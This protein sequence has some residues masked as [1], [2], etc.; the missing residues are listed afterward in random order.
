MKLL[1]IMRPHEGVDVRAEI[2]SRADAELRALWDLYGSDFVREM[3]T[4]GGPGAVLV[5]EA[6]SPDQARRSLEELPLLGNRV[7]DLEL[8]ELH[9]FTALRMLFK[10]PAV[11]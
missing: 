2:A 7:M 8:I 5:L 11:L 10:D 9:P 6:S 4:P 1:A 3:Y